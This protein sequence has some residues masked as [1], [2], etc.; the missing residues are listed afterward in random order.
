MLLLREECV[1]KDMLRRLETLRND[2]A[3]CAVIAGRAETR[4]KRELFSQLSR[5]LSMLADQVDK[6]I[7]AA[8]P[9]DT[10]LG[11]KNYEPF[12]THEE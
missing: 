7:S 11:R 12:P 6:A 10:F 1:M 4:E 3:E 5:H 8:A 2:A 9:S